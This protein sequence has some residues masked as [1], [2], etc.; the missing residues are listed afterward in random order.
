MAKRRWMAAAVLLCLLAGCAGPRFQ[1]QPI[2]T[3]HAEATPT[4][5]VTVTP[6]PKVTPDPT[7]TATP[8]P[9]TWDPSIPVRHKEL[10]SAGINTWGTQ[11]FTAYYEDEYGPYF[12]IDVTLPWTTA[13]GEGYNVINKRFEELMEKYKK[14][15]WPAYPPED[16]PPFAPPGILIDIHPYPTPAEVGRLVSFRFLENDYY[17]GVHGLCRA[18]V[19]TYDVTTGE[20]LAFNDFFSDPEEAEARIQ[21]EIQR[22]VE[23]DRETYGWLFYEGHI[24]PGVISLFDRELV[25]PVEDGFE[26]FYQWYSIGGHAFGAP[27]FLIPWEVLEGVTDSSVFGTA[28]EPGSFTLSQEKGEFYGRDGKLVYEYD[29]SLPFFHDIRGTNV[30]ISRYYQEWMT[31]LVESAEESARDTL[32]YADEQEV[33]FRHKGYLLLHAG[34]TFCNGDGLLQI[35]GTRESYG[36]GAAHP[37]HGTFSHTFD[38]FTGELIELPDLFTDWEGA[39]EVIWEAIHPQILERFPGYPPEGPA[40]HALEQLDQNPVFFLE[41]EGLTIHYNEYDIAAYVYGPSEF[42]VPKEL[43]ESL[44]YPDYLPILNYYP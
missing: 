23:A 19:E 32:L 12:D 11:R 9:L 4:E 18:W 35:R 39:K 16:R 24:N 2:P 29:I 30:S 10:F 7:P 42:F 36:A 44:V 6:T 25:Y 13:E 27:T 28:P 33:F 17:G 21:A 43:W 40:G 38:R 34:P 26:V 20:R 15:V 3:H 14:E 5:E 22:Q 1:R 31:E 37:L 41:T 8:V